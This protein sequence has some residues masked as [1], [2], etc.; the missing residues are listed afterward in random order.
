VNATFRQGDPNMALSQ[1]E[2]ESLMSLDKHRV[3]ETVHPFP[4]PG[5]HLAIPLLSADKREEFIL[6]ISRNRI[7][8]TRKGKYQTRAKTTVPICRLCFA[9]PHR[10]PDGTEIPDTHL[11]VFRDGYELKWAVPLDPALFTNPEDR[12]QLLHEFLAHVNITKP[13]NIEAD[14]F[15]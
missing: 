7:E 4:S 13:P 12:M 3:D 10:N 5:G 6:D 8:L 15:A 9:K 14:I 2:V 1:A 11:H